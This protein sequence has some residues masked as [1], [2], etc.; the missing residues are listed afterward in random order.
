MCQNRIAGIGLF[1]L[2]RSRPFSF[3]LCLGY[4]YR[5]SSKYFIIISLNHSTNA[6]ENGLE[7]KKSLVMKC[8]QPSGSR[9]FSQVTIKSVPF[10]RF[11]EFTIASNLSLTYITE[12]HHF[13]MP[14]SPALSRLPS[15]VFF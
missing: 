9:G 12:G 15:L 10:F 8:L 1:N 5:I 2:S 3:W 11:I 14:R 13:I 4:L 7:L 6:F